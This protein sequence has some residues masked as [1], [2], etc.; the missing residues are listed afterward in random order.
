MEQKKSMIQDMASKKSM[1][2]EEFIYIIGEKHEYYKYLFSKNI[3]YKDNMMISLNQIK[4]DQ[5][6][7]LVCNMILKLASLL[8]FLVVRKILWNKGYFAS[9]FFN[10]R[11]Q[12][13][14]YF[15]LVNGYIH[16]KYENSLKINHVYSYKKKLKFSND[17]NKKLKESGLLREFSHKSKLMTI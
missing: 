2:N 8:G 9:F 12:P 3:D 15:F 11:F 10:T 1:L 13:F 14:I 7:V 17:T 5:F 4:V 6:V 16:K